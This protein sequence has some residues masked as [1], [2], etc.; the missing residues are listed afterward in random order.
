VLQDDLLANGAGGSPE[1]LAAI[2]PVRTTCNRYF[3]WDGSDLGTWGEPRN[4]L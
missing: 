1:K 2:A 4:S 3:S